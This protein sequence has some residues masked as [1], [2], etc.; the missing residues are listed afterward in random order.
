MK[1]EVKLFH[2]DNIQWFI[3]ADETQYGFS[4]AGP[5]GGPEVQRYHNPTLTQCVEH[6]I[7]NDKNT[8]GVYCTNPFEVLPPIHF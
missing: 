1:S 8:A 4:T 7:K 3:N 5:K 2:D 6:V